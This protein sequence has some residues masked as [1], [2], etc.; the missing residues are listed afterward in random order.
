MQDL[1]TRT[2]QEP[3]R[4]AFIQAY[5][6]HGVCKTF[7]QGPVREDPTGISARSSV[8][9]LYKIMQGPPREDLSESPQDLLTRTCTRSCKGLPKRILSEKMFSQGQLFLRNGNGHGHVTRAILCEDSQGRRRAP[10]PRQPFCA[11]HVTRAI[12]ARCCAPGP[13]QP[14]YASWRSRNALGHIT[15][16][17]LCKNLEEKCC[18][19][20]PRQPF[21]ASL[22]SRNANGQVTRAQLMREFTGKNT[23]QQTEHPDQAPA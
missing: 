16:A 11:S 23:G 21:Y 5:A 14:F 10:G 15:R 1:E 13:R 19:P 7:T 2:S 8:K 18:A 12:H 4:R 6:R 3:H 9:D 20:G 22:R 17:I